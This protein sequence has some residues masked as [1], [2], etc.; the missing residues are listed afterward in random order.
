[1]EM[2]GDGRGVGETADGPVHLGQV[3]ARYHGG[4]L[5]VD[6]DLEPGRAPV[7]KLDPWMVFEVLIDAIAALTSLGTTSPR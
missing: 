5:V 6:A 2:V 4:R 7:D 3:A 1:M